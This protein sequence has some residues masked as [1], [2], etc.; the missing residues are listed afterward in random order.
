[1]KALQMARKEIETITSNFRLTKALKANI[2]AEKNLK[3]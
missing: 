1:M 2:T 3:L